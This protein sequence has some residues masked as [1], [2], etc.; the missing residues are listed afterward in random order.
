MSGAVKTHDPKNKK[1]LAEV[2]NRTMESKEKIALLTRSLLKYKQLY[3][4][5]LADDEGEAD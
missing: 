2:E 3:L 4:G 1:G 5:E